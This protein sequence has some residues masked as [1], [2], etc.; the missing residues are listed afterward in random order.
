MRDWC[1]GLMTISPRGDVK[2]ARRT[3]EQKVSGQGFPD[4]KNIKEGARK[5]KYHQIIWRGCW[6]I[7][8]GWRVMQ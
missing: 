7:V 3:A 5:I 2:L 8:V 4:S 6:N 1:R